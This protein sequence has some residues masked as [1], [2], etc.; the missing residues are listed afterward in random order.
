ME[1]TLSEILTVCEE[2][3]WSEELVKK[4]RYLLTED[5]IPKLI[6]KFAVV[7]DIGKI[8]YK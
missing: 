6:V 7:A 3:K 1:N 8:Y 4:L 2:N 5:N